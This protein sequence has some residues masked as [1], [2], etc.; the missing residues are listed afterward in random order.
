MSGSKS[1][2]PTLWVYMKLVKAVGKKREA[3][4][5]KLETLSWKV[6]NEMKKNEVGKFEPKLE[7]SWQSW[8]VRGE[9]GKLGLKLESDL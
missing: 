6:R 4:N 1:V 5:F 9:F 8:K 2:G 3:G 7:S